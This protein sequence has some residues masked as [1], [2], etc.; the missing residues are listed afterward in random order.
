VPG[1]GLPP[2]P[3]VAGAP[4]DD[5]SLVA[6]RQITQGWR[7][8]SE[9]ISDAI[10][11]VFNAGDPAPRGRLP[12]GTRP[13]DRWGISKDDVHVIKEGAYGEPNPTGWAGVT[14]DGHVIITGEDGEAKDVGHVDDFAH[15]PLSQ[16]PRPRN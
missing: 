11:N 4:V 13:I 16:F 7:A 2:P 12:Q 14:P 6:A 3:T 5:P 1:V 15:R 10:R 9:A 8:I